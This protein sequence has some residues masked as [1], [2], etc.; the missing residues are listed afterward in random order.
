MYMIKWPHR[1]AKNSLF[2][3]NIF[4]KVCVWCRPS[5]RSVYG[6]D[7]LICLCMGNTVEDVV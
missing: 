6:I 5:K 3:I 2:M 7:C 4:A 1:V